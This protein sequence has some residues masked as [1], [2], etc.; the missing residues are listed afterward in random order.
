MGFGVHEL[1]Q[2]AIKGVLLLKK[3]LQIYHVQERG[4]AEAMKPA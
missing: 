4:Q 3:W 2:E 1:K